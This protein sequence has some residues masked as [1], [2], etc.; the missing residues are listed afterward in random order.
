MLLF[1]CGCCDAYENQSPMIDLEGT[2]L[3][4]SRTFLNDPDNSKAFSSARVILLEHILP[5]TEE[6][7]GLL[8]G[9]GV[10]IF[11]LFAK[12][13]SMDQAV[14][15]RIKNSGVRIICKSYDD[16]ENT[17]IIPT[18]LS[19]A[20]TQSEIDHKRIL[21]LEVGGY[22]AQPLTKI[23]A[24]ARGHIAGVVEDT[25]FGHNRY[26]ALI[27]KIPVP[28]FSVARSEL[29][30]I[31]A[32]FVGQDA[33]M[34]MDHIL[35][36]VG[37]SLFGKRAVV[38]GYGMIGKNVART[39]KAYNMS[40]SVYDK[41][42]I[43]NLRAFNAGFYVNKKA[44]LIR[45]ADIVFSATGQQSMSYEDIEGCKDRAILVSV[46]SRDTEFDIKQLKA[47]ST[48]NQR[49]DHYLS[50]YHLPNG[51]EIGV[52]KDGTAVNFILPSL[53][54]E[55]LDFVFAEII[56]ASVMLLHSETKV[57]PHVLY[58][59]PEKSLSV[60]SKMWLKNVNW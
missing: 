22:F 43:R 48:S 34:A 55:I 21:I 17:N 56:T 50:Y 54:V 5:T 31:E 30:Q 11:A 27:E 26:N 28:V 47:V 44:E 32:Y 53:P 9:A 8:K 19:E 25:T 40:V 41:R 6:F 37:V 52:I 3:R 7:V 1:F 29:K 45:Q 23:P 24:K 33:V 42:D 39:L 59:V 51:K 58:S 36:D 10:E 15:T 13:Y 2:R 18:I 60:V 38:I 35:R 20:A 49:F 16:L 14:F 12:P 4:V 57:Q 46:G